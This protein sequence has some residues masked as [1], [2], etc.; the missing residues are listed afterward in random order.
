MLVRF[1]AAIRII[2]VVAVLTAIA[3]YTFAYVLAPLDLLRTNL[4][5]SAQFVVFPLASVML[6]LYG[7]L[8][9][10]FRLRCSRVET[11]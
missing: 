6:L 4:L 1:E 11:S 5:W 8:R 7:G 10:V 3:L 9:A 2:L